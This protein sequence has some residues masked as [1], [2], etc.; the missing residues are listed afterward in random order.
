M[1]DL[2]C[3]S[4]S[5]QH[6]KKR[7]G[8]SQVSESV[9]VFVGVGLRVVDVVL[10]DSQPPPNQP[11]L[12]VVTAVVDAGI[13]DDDVDVV[14]GASVVVVTLNDVLS[15]HPNQP[16]VRHDDVRYVVVTTGTV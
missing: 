12:H 8:V 1:V 4:G 5:S 3:L 15:T 6:P 2:C 14:V 11:D 10:V 13:D 9:V 7:P 16:G